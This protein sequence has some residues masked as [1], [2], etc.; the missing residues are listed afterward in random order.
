MGSFSWWTIVFLLCVIPLSATQAQGNESDRERQIYIP[1]FSGSDIAQPHS[2]MFAK[3]FQV[4]LIS[5]G[6][7]K[8]FT[9]QDLEEILQQEQYKEVLDCGDSSC[10][11]EIVMNFGIAYT[12]FGSVDKIDASLCSV[13]VK[14]YDGETPIWARAMDNDCTPRKRIESVEQLAVMFLRDSPLGGHKLEEEP[15]RGDERSSGDT[16]QQPVMGEEGM[17]EEQEQDEAPVDEAA[18]TQW[19]SAGFRINGGKVILDKPILFATVEDAR[20]PRYA[21]PTLNRIAREMKTHGNV[22][23][24]IHGHCDDS[25]RSSWQKRISRWRASAVLHYLVAQGVHK[26]RLHIQAQGSK[27]P[28][29]SSATDQGRKRNNRVDFTIFFK[30]DRENTR[31]QDRVERLLVEAKQF[32]QAQRCSMAMLRI[33]TAAKL[34]AKAAIGLQ[35]VA[36]CFVRKRAF[37][38]AIKALELYLEYQPRALDRRKVQRNIRQLQRKIQRGRGR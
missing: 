32:E 25:V 24:S 10:I 19:R 31:I 12:A 7:L 35:K 22:H 14:L 34:D 21:Y 16:A 27:Y 30:R 17:E 6:S 5:Q 23:L 2:A 38:D 3:R 1:D 29:E 8:A 15:P 11:N 4:T 18:A 20:V 9:K 26:N 13:T 28:L 33:Q 37:N 36:K